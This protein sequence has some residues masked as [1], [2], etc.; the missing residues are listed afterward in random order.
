M[1]GIKRYIL[2]AIMLAGGAY[3]YITINRASDVIA[4]GNKQSRIQNAERKADAKERAENGDDEDE[5]GADYAD[6]EEDDSTDNSDE[7][8]RLSSDWDDERQ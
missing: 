1:D 5:E 2:L 4:E 8:F 7:D 3:Q 6:A